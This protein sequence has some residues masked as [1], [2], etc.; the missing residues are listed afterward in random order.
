MPLPIT[1]VQQELL[2]QSI[3]KFVRE[4]KDAE[5]VTLLGVLAKAG[6][7]SDDVISIPCHKTEPHDP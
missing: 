4:C 7:K 1:P 2:L 6:A 3:R 5:P